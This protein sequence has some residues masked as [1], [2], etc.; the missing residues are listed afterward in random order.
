M[1]IVTSVNNNY[2]LENI[3]NFYLW[4]FIVIS[5]CNDLPVLASRYI[6]LLM[7]K[8]KTNNYLNYIYGDIIKIYYIKITWV[9]TNN[10]I[11]LIYNIFFPKSKTRKKYTRLRFNQS[12]MLQFD[13][14]YNII[15]KEFRFLRVFDI[16]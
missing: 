11:L 13:T 12:Y 10:N 5:F 14:I 15:W 16:K 4:I 3:E 1:I 2:Q 6:E 9:T 8:I 7:Y